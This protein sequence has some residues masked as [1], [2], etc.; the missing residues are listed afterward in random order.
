MILHGI[1]GIST[2]KSMP[3]VPP[4]APSCLVARSRYV[5]YFK[6]HV[7][8]LW[9]KQAAINPDREG[10]LKAFATSDAGVD[11][12][13]VANFHAGL[14]DEPVH[15]AV[16]VEV[17]RWIEFS[18]PGTGG[19]GSRRK[20]PTVGHIARMPRGDRGFASSCSRKLLTRCSSGC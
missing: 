3:I 14:S 13:V 6:R 8:W 19:R 15:F 12:I 7:G 16:G 9:R 10:R 4:C 18:V 17:G 20:D 1:D 2:C 11:C 5:T